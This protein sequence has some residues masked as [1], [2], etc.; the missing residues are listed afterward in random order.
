LCNLPKFS[1][2]NL[3]VGFDTS[4]DACV[5][6]ISEEMALVQTVDFFPPVVDDPYLYGQIAAANAL[7]DIYAMGAKPTL[8]MN[9]LCYPSCLAQ[10]TV[11]AILAGGY[12]KVKEAGAVIAGGHTIQDSEPKYGLCV[13][14]FIDPK[15]ILKNNGAKAGDI[16]ILTKALGTGILTTAA[17]A[18]L[19]DEETFSAAAQSMATLNKLAAE[20]ACAFHINA[21]TDITGFGLLGHTNEMASS[22]NLT[23]H[24]FSQ[25]IGILPKA[26]DFAD[27][28]I[29]P[30]GAYANSDYLKDK[31]VFRESVR[32]VTRDLLFD[33]QTSGGLLF[34]VPK[35]DADE[36]LARLIQCTPCARIIGEMTEQEQTSLVVE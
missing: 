12:D 10:E 16:L 17:K 24:I 31:V 4:D 21:C 19:T 3:L 27:M 11:Q 35:K 25:E 6:K 26:A 34:S 15:K 20:T 2:P 14:G 7:S 29:I 33:P 5:Y 32:R 9:L 13:S 28:G 8:A 22:S 30:A 18:L 36:L 1:D 23:A